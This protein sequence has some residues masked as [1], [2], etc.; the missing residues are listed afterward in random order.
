MY[1]RL[2]LEGDEPP[3]EPGSS[4]DRSHPVG[5]EA[6][7]KAAGRP[8]GRSNGTMEAR[9]FAERV[10]ASRHAWLGPGTEIQVTTIHHG[11]SG[12]R[13]IQDPSSDSYNTENPHAHSEAVPARSRLPLKRSARPILEDLEIRLALSTLNS[14][15]T[16]ALASVPINAVGYPIAIAGVPTTIDSTVCHEHDAAGDPVVLRGQQDLVQRRAGERSGPDHRDRGRG[17]RP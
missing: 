6:T 1:R 7:K 17:R 4:F 10:A 16:A 12:P 2:G 13:L 15:L 3:T 8:M 9:N 14:S 11:N 5:A